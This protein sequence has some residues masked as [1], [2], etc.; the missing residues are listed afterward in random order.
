[1]RKE[2]VA[3]FDADFGNAGA[4]IFQC[5]RL[6]RATVGSAHLHLRAENEARHLGTQP[7]GVAAAQGQGQVGRI[8]AQQLEE[9]AHPALR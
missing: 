2:L 9:S 4:D 8:R 7:F 1:M 5:R 3:Q 6:R